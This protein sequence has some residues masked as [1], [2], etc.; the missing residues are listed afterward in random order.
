MAAFNATIEPVDS[1]TRA[2]SAKPPHTAVCITPVGFRK[3]DDVGLTQADPS[4]TAEQIAGVMRIHSAPNPRRHGAALHCTARHC[5]ALHSEL[6]LW[7]RNPETTTGPTAR[8]EQRGRTLSVC[9]SGQYPIGE[10]INELKIAPKMA[11]MMTMPRITSNQSTVRMMPTI[12]E[13]FAS[14]APPSP[15]VLI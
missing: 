6:R 2:C 8:F 11:V 3:R 4:D 14:P 15:D 10:Y 12:S 5:T 9:V 13:A 1:D 7:S